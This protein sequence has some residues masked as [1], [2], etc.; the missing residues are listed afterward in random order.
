MRNGFCVIAIIVFASCADGGKGNVFTV[1]GT[2]KNTSAKTIYLEE[3]V[4][5]KP[6]V[7]VDSAAVVNGKFT[8]KTAAPQESLY[9]LRL[10]GATT[11]LALLINDNPTVTVSVDA[12]NALQSYT[13][14]GSP[15]SQ[16]IIDFDRKMAELGNQLVAS[17]KA[18]D[19]LEAGTASDS[20]RTVAYTTANGLA[21]SMK[22]VTN[23]YLAKAAGPILPLYIA[24]AYQ[25][26]A[27]N[28][29]LEG[30]SSEELAAVI[31]TVAAKHPTHTGLQDVQK[32]LASPAPLKNT[33]PASTKAPEFSQPGVDGKPVS[34]SSFR[35]K[36][37]LLDFWAS[38]C[39]PCRKENPN[40]VR[41]YNAFKDKNFTV[42]SVS[43]DR[44]KAAWLKAIQDDSLTW[45]HAS[46]LQF[47]N[48]AA[49]GLYGVQSIPAN[50]LIDPEGNVVGRD[51][52]I[53]EMVRT[54]RGVI[55]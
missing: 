52:Y 55:K 40:V 11:P 53:D 15:A 38:W 13:V 46:D 17:G 26:T 20:L 39:A 37:V 41:A 10:D 23:D 28:L 19:S 42:F 29:G 25:N 30:F 47:W 5:T 22:A 51:L 36:W 6:P 27:S 3:T 49:A 32:S 7:I 21:A 16:T 14:Q 50:F 18:I 4:P 48:N 54:L 33:S 44:D 2:V 9:Q 43:L 35:G 45:T 12:T 24:S 8:L 34:L 31:K 1:E